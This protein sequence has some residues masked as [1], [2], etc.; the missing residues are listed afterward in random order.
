MRLAEKRLVLLDLDGTLYL[1]ERP[2][3]GAGEFLRY[4]LR[5]GRRYRFLTNNSSRSRADYLQK[6]E[7]LDLPARE[8]DFLTSADALEAY[9][10][11]RRPAGEL[12]YVLGTASLREQLCRAGF[13]LTDRP[14][15]EVS[16]L[17]CGL[18]TELTY[19]KLEDACQLLF[20]GAD[21]I[22][23]HLDWACPA[24][25]GFA[26]DCGCICEM[27]RRTT[28]RRPTVVGKPRPEMALLA[29]E[30]TGC[31]PAETLMVGD[32]L[33]TDIACGVNAGIDTALL[34]T[35]GETFAHADRYPKR[36]TEIYPDIGALL[37]AWK[38]A[39]A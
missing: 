39:D 37:Q 19:R 33:N 14:E 5:T 28:G 15:A 21:F 34:L 18:D 4:L 22:A 2:Y 8:E 20:R 29:M 35:T 12:Y 36:P 25:Y 24:P 17:L 6:M 27:L 31:A 1:G 38:E 26:P 10:L 30:R 32:R 23:T 7:R 9:L 11:R 16:A 3:D 13:R